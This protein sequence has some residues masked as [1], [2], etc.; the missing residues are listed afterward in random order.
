MEIKIKRVYEPPHP[1][2]GKRILVDRL[3]PRGISKEHAKIDLW[4]K[5]IAPSTALRGWFGH[6]P[7]KWRE[8]VRRYHKELGD[9]AQLGELIKLAKDGT[10]TLVYAAKDEKHNNAFALKDMLIKKV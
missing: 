4:V 1:S 5:D 2:D 7:H 9:S 3:W 10:I 8:F 6:D